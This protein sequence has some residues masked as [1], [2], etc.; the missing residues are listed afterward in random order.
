MGSSMTEK[1]G[2]SALSRKCK[3]VLRMVLCSRQLPPTSEAI[4]RRPEVTPKSESQLNVPSNLARVSQGHSRADSSRLYHHDANAGSCAYVYILDSGINVSHTEFSGR[5]LYGANFIPG[6]PDCDET[7]HDTR[8]ASIIGGETY[9]V[10][11]DCTMI[12]VKTTNNGKGKM[13][14]IT[15]AIH[16]FIRDAAS[17]GVSD[18]S[19]INISTG[20]PYNASVNHAVEEATNAGI[21]V[22]VSAGN[23]ARSACGQSPASAITA[24]TVAATGPDDCR[25][26][27]SNYG[28]S[29]DIFAPGFRVPVASWS[30]D[31]GPEYSSGTSAA[32][33]HVSGLAAYFVTNKNLRGFNAVRRRILKAALQGVVTDTRGSGNRLASKCA[34]RDLLFKQRR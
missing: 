10:A 9:G 29:V 31:N 20:G 1:R 14:Y 13:S 27:S 17:R 8:M 34:L 16:W 6:K 21:T 23:D 26:P 19:V 24:I 18:R 32:A 5:A 15:E 33:A 30:V 4:T 12:S 7:G 28:P 2:I 11:K 25:R 22:V 3:Q